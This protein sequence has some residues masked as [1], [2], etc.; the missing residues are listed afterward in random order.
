MDMLELKDEIGQMRRMIE[1]MAA[2]SPQG[3]SSVDPAVPI[4]SKQRPSPKVS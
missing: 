3:Q 4:S 2:E 1:R